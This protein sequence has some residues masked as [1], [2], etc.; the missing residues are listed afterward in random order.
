MDSLTFIA[1][2][3]GILVLEIGL[4]L[5]AIIYLVLRV[6]KTVT[7]VE[8]L[9]YTIEDKLSSFKTGWIR[10]LQGAASLVTGFMGA[11]NGRD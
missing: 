3:M 7:A 6:N 11:R 8:V 9:A 1:V 10:A 5:G 4:V 2:C